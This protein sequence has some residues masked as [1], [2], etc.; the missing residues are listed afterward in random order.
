[1]IVLPVNSE[2][3]KRIYVTAMN[4]DSANESDTKYLLGVIEGV[5]GDYFFTD[6]SEAVEEIGGG[7]ERD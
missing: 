5:L 2:G 1:M 6:S 7:Y 4:T 3:L